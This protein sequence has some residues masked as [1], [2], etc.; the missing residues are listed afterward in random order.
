[1]PIPSFFG[2]TAAKA[3]DLLRNA[4][5]RFGVRF[6]RGVDVAARIIGVAVFA[7]ALVALTSI[8]IYVGFEHE[9]V[10]RRLLRSL[11][12]G[13]QWIFIGAAMFG[14]IFR[15]TVLS[16]RGGWVKRMCDVALL[17]TIL[18]VIFPQIGA[19]PP[20][21]NFMGLRSYYFAIVGIYS[22]AEVSYGCMNM[23][24]RRTNPS[25][26]LSVS[27]LVF[28]IAGTFVL[29][30]P[31]C[32]TRPVDFTDA[33]F[34][35]AS[36]VSMTGLSPVDI[37]STFTPL[38]W[39]VI[40]VLMQI[41]ALGVLTITS[42][43]S[44]FFSGRPSIFNQLLMRDFIYSKSMSAIGSVLLYILAFTVTVEAAGA[45]AIYF[46]LPPELKPTMMQGAGT[47]AFH[48]IAAF[49]NSG[50]ST[51][52]GGLANSY[53]FDGGIGIYA[54]MTV[55]I[56]AGGIG[57]PNLVNF[58]EAIRRYL[59]AGRDRLLRRPRRGRPVHVYD[60]NTKLVL[61]TSGF[62][63][64]AGAV[65][66]FL[67]EHG[68]S[69]ADLPLG[70]QVMQSLFYSATARSAG[71]T[72][73]NPA[74]FLN[75]TLIVLMFLMWIGG[76]SQSM[77]GGIKVNAFATAMLNL[78]ALIAGHKG[79]A[80][81][82][83]RIS[84]DSV[85]RA[86][87]TIVLSLLMFVAFTVTVMLVDP[88]LRAKAVIFECLSALTTNGMSLGITSELSATSKVLLSMLMFIGRVGLLSVLMGL[89][90]GCKDLSQHFPSEEI[91]IS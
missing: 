63:Y 7:A 23:L 38:G 90:R 24:G 12:R 31:R 81:F 15:N 66:F 30:L 28:I 80:A 51:I 70:K 37:S 71:F 10:N 60:L 55:L 39:T 72:P 48:A 83:R 89:M 6:S 46:A 82:G 41:G 73:V 33:L 26:I 42:F 75:V 77:A 67:L 8:V 59:A 19:L 52:P 61:V 54:V 18:P 68:N 44:V 3:A 53:L 74:G 13:S 47:A 45:L 5:Y 57:F 32:A 79:I 27:F 65:I 91:V 22:V 86:N 20:P 34:V 35:A 88:Q 9:T 36:A 62:L 78:R 43:F 50:L 85:R 4:A 25:L 87:G 64:V 16:H 14:A 17:T 11:I 2:P 40:A 1:M 58:K 29:M 21:W 49:T 56:L 69:L 76:A 84:A